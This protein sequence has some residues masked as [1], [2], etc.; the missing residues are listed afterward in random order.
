[1][2]TLTLTLGTTFTSGRVRRSNAHTHTHT[3]DD[4]HEWACA[5][6]ECSHSHSHSGRPSR[7]G[8]CGDRMLT[9]TLTLGTT[10]TSGRVWRSNAH[11][12]AH[13]RDDLHEWACVEIECSHSRSHSGR[14][15]RVGV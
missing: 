8:V 6:I 7:V 10:F 2:L 15:S 14:P 4:L 11:T 9:L 1:M 3:R 13:T 12:H 5:E